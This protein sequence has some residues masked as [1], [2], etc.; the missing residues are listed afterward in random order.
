MKWCADIAKESLMVDQIS[1][2]WSQVFPGRVLQMPYERIVADLE[3]AAR[4]MLHHCG[5]PWDESVLKFHQNQR[6]VQ[7]ASLAQVCPSSFLLSPIAS[8]DA[9]SVDLRPSCEACLCRA[10]SVY[11]VSSSALS[12][13]SFSDP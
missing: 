10:E 1:H 4:D 6:T 8:L 11:S 2:H 5:L 13:C 7:T 12:H 9:Q 3:S